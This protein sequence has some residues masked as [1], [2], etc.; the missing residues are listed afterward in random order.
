MIISFGSLNTDLIFDLPRAPGP[1]ETLLARDFILQPGGKGANQ[2]VAAGRAGGRVAMIGAVGQDGLA[3]LALSGMAGAKVDIVGVARVPA[4]TGCASIVV[5]D[6]GGN[7][8]VVASGANMQARATQIDAALLRPGT[9]LLLQM[10]IP[11]R[12][13]A[14]AV[15]QARAGGA[16]PILNLA[17]AD[18]ATLDIEVL[19][20]CG[21]L[22]VNEH[23]AEVAA[24]RLGCGTDAR[25]L[26]AA[27]GTGVLRSL[28]GE[29][30]EAMTADGYCRVPA[31]PITPVDTT[32]AGDCLIGVLAVGLDEGL[33]FE[34]ALRRATI[35]AA[36]CCQRHG[37]QS[38]LPWRAEIDAA[39]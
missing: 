19:R 18:P 27:L 10:E 22:V 17:P 29:G 21:L 33:P 1:G 5:D 35:A 24:A 26:A 7:R 9:L 2:A 36:L 12:E 6:E 20:A 13:V 14:I 4:P 34:A 11:P 31:L 16:V 23:E 3:D 30:S 8:I 38:S 25:S 15:A 39:G 37:S 28:G 32:A